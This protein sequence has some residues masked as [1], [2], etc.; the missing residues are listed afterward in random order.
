M[1]QPPQSNSEL[2]KSLGINLHSAQ[3]PASSLMPGPQGTSSGPAVSASD[4]SGQLAKSWMQSMLVQASTQPGSSGAKRPG[5]SLDCVSDEVSKSL[6][7]L[8][9]QASDA[10]GFGAFEDPCDTKSLNAMMS[11]HSGSYMPALTDMLEIGYDAGGRRVISM[12]NPLGN[13]SFEIPINPPMP[14]SAMSVAPAP[15]ALAASRAAPPSHHAAALLGP[16]GGFESLLGIHAQQ[17][18]AMPAPALVASTPSKDGGAGDSD[19]ARHSDSSSPDQPML[20]KLSPPLGAAPASRKLGRRPPLPKKRLGARTAAPS[21]AP[22]T[23]DLAG[24]G[25]SSASTPL[26]GSLTPLSTS[27]MLSG[28][29]S[30]RVDRQL[31][32]AGARPLLFVRPSDKGGQSRRRKRRCVSSSDGLPAASDDTSESG[33]PGEATSNQWQRISEQ[34]RRDAMRENFDLLKRM[35]PK[36]YM[37]SDDGRELA[38]PVLLSRFL[39]WV[40]DTLIEMENLRSEV[41]SLR[42][43]ARRPALQQPDMASLAQMPALPISAAPLSHSLSAP[44]FSSAP[45]DFSVSSA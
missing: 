10:G 13:L 8:L 2:N 7:L 3:G 26:L 39:R 29:P 30:H 38:R 28:L 12:P 40:D 31:A 21:P 17:G 4:Y 34:R 36:E 35:L 44:G 11:A 14:S 24:L 33:A 23:D 45:I 9:S 43:A 5:T 19:E 27:A 32:A 16:T 41:A 25:T 20:H 6:S 15:Y 37:D 42:L 22:A 1:R 18:A